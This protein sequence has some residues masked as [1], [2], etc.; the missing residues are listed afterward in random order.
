MD[1]WSRGLKCRGRGQNKCGKYG[2][3]LW[4]TLRI[5]AV[6]NL[7]SLWR[8][9]RNKEVGSHCSDSFGT[10]EK[11][12]K[13]RP[14]VFFARWRLGL[15]FGIA[16][17]ARNIAEHIKPRCVLRPFR[18]GLGVL[19]WPCVELGTLDMWWCRSTADRNAVV[20]HLIDFATT[21]P[22]PQFGLVNQGFRDAHELL[23]RPQ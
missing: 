6:E 13:S 12:S 11:I 9:L 4:F 21:S 19:H 20:R 1:E 14:S 16:E 22:R 17:T 7:C 23:L 18:A 5:K 3:G 15:R 10:S 8:R 2:Y